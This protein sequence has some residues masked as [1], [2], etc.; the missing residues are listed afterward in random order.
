[1]ILQEALL[2]AKGEQ[3]IKTCLKRLELGGFDSDHGSNFTVPLQSFLIGNRQPGD[4][5][6]TQENQ[7]KFRCKCDQAAMQLLTIQPL[8]DE[9]RSIGG[10][11]GLEW[12]TRP[13][14]RRPLLNGMAGLYRR[15][16]HRG[17]SDVRL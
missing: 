7:T 4:A 3:V 12:L 10:S 17:T 8:L 11:K 1:M 5:D 16:C 15:R 13:T 14:F 9:R 2:A 6:A